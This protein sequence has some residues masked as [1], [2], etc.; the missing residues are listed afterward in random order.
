M[1]I[2]TTLVPLLLGLAAWT[3]AVAGIFSKR[4][5]LMCCLS[6]FSGACAL[7]FP[8]YSLLQWVNEKDLSAVMDCTHAYTLCAGIL[9]IVN[10]LLNLI[11][12]LLHRNKRNFCADRS[13]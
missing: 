1:D 12:A 5:P 11:S 13:E 8:L 2:V 7:W 6:W 3:L 4:Y 9:L 10:F